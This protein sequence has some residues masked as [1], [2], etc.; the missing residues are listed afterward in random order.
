MNYIIGEDDESKY[1]FLPEIGNQ[2]VGWNI[3]DLLNSELPILDN[4]KNRIIYGLKNGISPELDANLEEKTIAKFSFPI[5]LLLIKS[6]NQSYLV[7]RFALAESR[8]V[9]ELLQDEN[10]DV[11]PQIF[12]TLLNIHLSQND[13]VSKARNSDYDFFIKNRLKYKIELSDYLSRSISLP[14]NKW[15]LVNRSVSNG[16]VFLTQDELVTLLREEIYQ[17]IRSKIDEIIIPPSLLKEDV[18]ISAVEQI[19]KSA[20]RPPTPRIQVFSGTYPP[21]V[22]K[23]IEMIQKGDQV[24]HSGKF[25]MTTFLLRAGKTVDEVIDMYPTNL[26]FNKNITKY[27]VEHIA[28]LKGGGTKYDVPSCSTMKM[29]DFCFK[30]EACG[31]IRNPLQFKN[32]TPVK[33]HGRKNS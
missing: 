30:T 12:K 23:A 22:A 8:R 13:A 9:E 6:T 27:Q 10:P 25:L 21:C 19:L 16:F 4:A 15:R 33:K 2:M 3:S 28:G 31:T 1:P 29:K 32:E 17:M 11:I 5:A 18:I 14:K 7:S 24:S 20:P 26:G